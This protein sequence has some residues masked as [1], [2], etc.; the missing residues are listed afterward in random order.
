MYANGRLIARRVDGAWHITADNAAAFIAMMGE[1]SVLGFDTQLAAGDRAIGSM[2][3]V[4]GAT[5]D[6]VLVEKME[7]KIIEGIPLTTFEQNVV[8]ATEWSGYATEILNELNNPIANEIAV[9][10]RVVA[11]LETAEGPVIVASGGAQLTPGQIDLAVSMGFDPI[12]TGPVALAEDAE[13]RAVSMAYQAGLTPRAMG[14]SKDIC[15]GC[16]GTLQ[17]MKAY[18]SGRVAAWG[19]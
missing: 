11:V 4:L 16:T 7:M 6:E 12:R 8:R 1:G 18:V 5:E 9:E 10:R 19:N 2:A 13:V 3:F 17:G 15:P 14:V